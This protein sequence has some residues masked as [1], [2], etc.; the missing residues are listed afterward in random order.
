MRLDTRILL[1]LVAFALVD[2][3]HAASRARPSSNARTTDLPLEQS[4]QSPAEWFTERARA[5]GLDF[6]HFNGM[7]GE[8]YFEEIMGSGV[9]LLDYDN[10]GD[11]DIY[12]VQGQ[13]LGPRKTLADAL[14]P[15]RMPL[16]LTDRLYRND[17]ETGADGSR[18]L[19]FTDVTKGSGLDVQSYGMGVATGD[20]DNDG[21]I[22]VYR[23]RR[24]PDQMFRNNGDGTFTDVSARVGT[25]QR[26]WSVS[27]SFLDF[28]RDGW[29]DLYV[30]NYVNNDET[31]M[32]LSALGERD[33][34]GP[35]G[36]E[37]VPDRLYRNRGN[38]TFEDV[39][40]VA[41]VAREYGRAMGVVA[42]DVNAD[43]WVDIYVAND[44]S[45]NL[46]WLN[47]HD[48]TFRNGALLAGVALD[49][50]GAVQAGMGV[51]AGDFDNDGDEDLLVTNLGTQY[52]TLYI[53]D[54]SGLFE[55]R[56]TASGLGTPRQRYTGF[57]TLFFDYDNDGWLDVLVV[58]GAVF[59]KRALAAAK[60]PYPLHE[61]NQLFRNL[62]N[63]RF[64]DV[65]ARAGTVFQLSEVSR[66]AAFGDLD[67]D[68]DTDVVVT[69]N[70]G[71]VRLLINNVGNRNRWLGLRL[72]GGK[73]PRPSTS[74]GRPEPVEG[75]DML[76]ARVGVFRREGAPLWRRARTDGSYGSAH[77]PRVLVG[78]GAATAVPRVRVVWPSGRIEEWT[79]LTVNQWRTLTEGTGQS[80]GPGR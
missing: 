18:T 43:G 3:Q 12:L 15:P 67:N 11:L 33:Y 21:W 35:Q 62:G 66:G 29:L 23:T 7:S 10:D 38:G 27:A 52:N 60:D 19:R 63:G 5:V 44:M 2:T 77:D 28:D 41:R 26:G 46:L 14:M 75:R 20:F 34:C 42:A 50:A 25:N 36:F 70:S 4:A 22:D 68:G 59:T 32:C 9:A 69:N 16:P 54:G 64:E 1:A 45:E 79:N 8:Y 78:L 65:T 53:N 76:G 72:V 47:Q 37:P 48:G 56:S 40:A 71:P 31:R 74:S 73:P 17:L 61:P 80:Q 49:Q 51:D 58:N 6:A 24:G 55:D 30:G 39:T 57:G 13:M